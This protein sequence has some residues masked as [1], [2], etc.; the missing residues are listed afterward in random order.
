MVRI[1]GTSNTEG[2]QISVSN[3]F[4]HPNWDPNNNANDEYDIAVLELATNACSATVDINSNTDISLTEGQDLKLIGFGLTE[5][6]NQDSSST[7][8]KQVD[9]GFIPTATCDEEFAGISSTLHVCVDGKTAGEGSCN[10]K[11]QC[12]L[13]GFL[14][15]LHIHACHFRR[16]LRRAASL[17]KLRQMGPDRCQQLQ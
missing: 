4:L 14:P 1:G 15:L 6:G 17:Q 11:S 12:D 2:E 5:D 7:V 16:R 10:G 13:S 3:V 8:L 9:L